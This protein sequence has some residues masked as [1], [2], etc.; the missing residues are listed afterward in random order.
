MKALE[1][2][3]GRRYDSPGDLAADIESTRVGRFA[4][5]DRILGDER[6]FAE[7]RF[8]LITPDVAAEL[9]AAGHREDPADYVVIA[10]PVI[11]EVAR[12]LSDPTR[13]LF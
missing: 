13:V 7:A 10:D 9:A 4:V 3:R 1:K 11:D 12:S 2:D 6:T 8:D 5:E